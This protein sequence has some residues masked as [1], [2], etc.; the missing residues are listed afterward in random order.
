LGHL[1]DAATID[2][3]DHW[4]GLG[5]PRQRRVH[6]SRNPDGGFA[7]RDTTLLRQRPSSGT[8]VAARDVRL[9]AAQAQLLLEALVASP[10]FFGKYEPAL[11]LDD[12][13]RIEIE[14]VT[15][16]ADRPSRFITE[17]VG[18]DH[19][20]WKYGDKSTPFVVPA[21]HPG[22]A[23]RYLYSVIDGTPRPELFAGLEP[24][25]RAAPRQGRRT[26]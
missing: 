24:A 21:A 13:P 16:D 26:W 20:P 12:Y 4:G 3:R 5:R 23:L 22:R 11:A 10:V 18:P 15:G 2:V 1:R 14:I 19:A 17:S 7:G 6:L 8:S 25:P 9:T